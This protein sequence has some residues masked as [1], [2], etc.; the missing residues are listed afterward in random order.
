MNDWW[1]SMEYTVRVMKCS[2]YM[3]LFSKKDER[4]HHLLMIRWYF[5]HPQRQECMMIFCTEE[6]NT[7]AKCRRILRK[8]NTATLKQ[9][10]INA[11]VK[12]GISKHVDIAHCFLNSWG[13][14]EKAT[15]CTSTAKSIAVQIRNAE[16]GDP[17][18]FSSFNSFNV[19]A[20]SPF[21]GQWLIGFT[22]FIVL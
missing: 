17:L 7:M 3:L 11:N 4:S 16:I 5:T 20:F 8:M 2:W 22:V 18:N 12:D 9:R 10:S 14:L 21:W 15:Q 6:R 1:Y 19:L 13:K